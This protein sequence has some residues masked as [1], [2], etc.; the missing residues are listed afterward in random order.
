MDEAQL[1]K[2]IQQGDRKSFQTLVE[3]YQRM[4]VNTC[5]GIVHN[6]DD[7]EDLAQDVFLEIFRTAGNYRGEAKL[8]TWLYRIATNRSLN[9]I[10]NK[11]RK[12]FFQSLEEAF[13]GGRN[14]NNE[15][16][17]YHSDQPD[18]NITDQQRSDLLHR[19]ID[20]LPEKQRTAFTLNKYEELTYQQIAEI[21]EISLASVESLIH[22]AKKNLQEQLLDC[23][24]KKC[25]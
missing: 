25:V 19:A 20:Q 6:Q 4:V 3:T 9:L 14:R 2:G 10:R 22:R 18:R 17:E 16:S 24:K 1:I 21:M 23:Y 7:A 11:K 8:S 5:L 13:T 12:G 15:I